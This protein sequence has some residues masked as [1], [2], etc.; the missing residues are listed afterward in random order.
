M[1]VA[2]KYIIDEKGEKTSVL[3]P[4]KTWNNLNDKYQ[5]LQKKLEILTGIEDAVDEIK[6]ARNKGKKLQSLSDFLNE[7]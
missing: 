1:A 5:K 6:A 3:V 2:L 4:L 7:N